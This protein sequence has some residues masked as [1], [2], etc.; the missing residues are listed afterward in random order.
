MHREL[1]QLRLFLFQIGTTDED[2]DGCEDDP[3][4]CDGDEDFIL[5][6][7]ERGGNGSRESCR[8]AV[9]P[10]S[11]PEPHVRIEEQ[12]HGPSKS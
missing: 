12:P 2:D 3:E 10:E 9:K 8:V 5:G 7:R 1:F 6:S 4:R 11:E